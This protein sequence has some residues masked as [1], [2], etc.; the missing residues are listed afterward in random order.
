MILKKSILFLSCFL[1]FSLKS[2]AQREVLSLNGEWEIDESVMADKRPAKFN[3]L[4]QVPGLV[5][6]SKPGI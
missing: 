3:H 5:N 1:M 2:T 6:T 4:V